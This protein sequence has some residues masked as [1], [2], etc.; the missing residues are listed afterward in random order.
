MRGLYETEIYK[1]GLED[2]FGSF[3]ARENGERVEFVRR[4]GYCYLKADKAKISI[5]I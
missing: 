2:V 3:H 5:L 1:R 4:H